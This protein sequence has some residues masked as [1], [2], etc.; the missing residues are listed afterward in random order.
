VRVCCQ[1]EVS[2]LTVHDRD[3]M[4]HARDFAIHDSFVINYCYNAC[5]L[6]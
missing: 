2:L 5:V 3:G 1:L 4:L 6:E